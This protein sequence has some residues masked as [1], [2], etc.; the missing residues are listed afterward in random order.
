MKKL[1]FFVIASLA[2]IVCSCGKNATTT[3]QETATSVANEM[4]EAAANTPAQPQELTLSLTVNE[5]YCFDGK[6]SVLTIKGGQPFDDI[7]APYKVVASKPKSEMTGIKIGKL[8]NNNGIVTVDVEAWA[9]DIDGEKL[10]LTVTD[11]NGTKAKVD[12]SAWYCP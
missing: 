3:T 6:P 2:I 1:N 9:D 12:V 11:A 4:Q 10:T 7:N 5:D 8:K